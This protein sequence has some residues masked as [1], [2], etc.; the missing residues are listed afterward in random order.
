[1]EQQKV[2]SR[3]TNVGDAA[4]SGAAGGALVGSVGGLTGAIIGAFAGGILAAFLVISA[5]KPSQKAKQAEAAR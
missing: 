4:I 3:W 5:A 1:M 2:N